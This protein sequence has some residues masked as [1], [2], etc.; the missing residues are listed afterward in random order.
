[1]KVRIS[2]AALLVKPSATSSPA[3]TITMKSRGDWCRARHCIASRLAAW[4]TGMLPS[5]FALTSNRRVPVFLSRK[6]KSLGCTWS[7]AG[8]GESCFGFFG[9]SIRPLTTNVLNNSYHLL[10]T[11]NLALEERLAFTAWSVSAPHTLQTSTFVTARDATLHS[12]RTG[13]RH[14]ADNHPLPR[15]PHEQRGRGRASEQTATR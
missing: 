7:P 3:W 4:S 13:R 10:D 9:L 1:M 5:S 11:D 6:T 8:N 12:N 2:F 14:R 15:A